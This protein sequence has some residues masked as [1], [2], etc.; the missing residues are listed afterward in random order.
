M[1]MIQ[2]GQ[3]KVARFPFTNVTDHPVT[4]TSIETFCDCLKAKIDKKEYKPG[5]SGEV[6]IEFNPKGFERDYGAT[7]LVKTDPG[8][9][10][11]HLTVLGFV[12]PSWPPNNKP[13][14]KGNPGS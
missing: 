1:G 9:I 11:T 5:E 6:A 3:I 14:A 8:D 4:I 13:A 2:P 12:V 10:P 7:I